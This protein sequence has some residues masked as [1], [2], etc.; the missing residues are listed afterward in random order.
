M[1]ISATVRQLDAAI[2]SLKLMPFIPR[3][4]VIRGVI[5][6]PVMNSVDT[7]PQVQKRKATRIPPRGENVLA[8]AGGTNSVAQYLHAREL[9]P[10]LCKIIPYQERGPGR[11]DEWFGERLG[12]VSAPQQS[13]CLEY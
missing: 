7:T 11:H 9:R 10:T 12:Q 4:T 5:T 1:K 8:S 3:T 6:I 2:Q 13:R